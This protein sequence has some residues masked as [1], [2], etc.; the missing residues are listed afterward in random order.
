MRSNLCWWVGDHLRNHKLALVDEG[1]LAPLR[2]PHCTVCDINY[3]VVS[4]NKETPIYT[5]NTV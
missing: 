1:N 5:H 2:N 3:T 4:L